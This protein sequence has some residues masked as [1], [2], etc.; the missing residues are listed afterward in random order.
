MQAQ[1]SL[2]APQPSSSLGSSRQTRTA[3]ILATGQ[4]AFCFSR[5]PSRVQRGGVWLDRKSH[6]F[7][8]WQETEETGKRVM[9]TFRLGDYEVRKRECARRVSSIQ[10]ARPDLASSTR[11]L[12]QK[13]SVNRT[14]DA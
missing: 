13:T 14:R 1:A 10:A 8:Q 7:G 9:R 2:S 12:R 5:Y 4:R 3:F 6:G 11:P